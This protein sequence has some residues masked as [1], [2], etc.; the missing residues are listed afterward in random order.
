MNLLNQDFVDDDNPTHFKSTPS[1]WD[2]PAEIW[3]QILRHLLI[4]QPEKRDGD[5]LVVLSSE[6]DWTGQNPPNN[7]LSSQ[8]LG[9][10]RANYAIGVEILYGENVF[11][12]NGDDV[13]AFPN[14][15]SDIGR[16]NVARLRHYRL[17]HRNAGYE[18]CRSPPHY[19]PHSIVYVNGWCRDV[20][21]DRLFENFSS[22][23]NLETLSVAVDLPS[24]KMRDHLAFV[25]IGRYFRESGL[26]DQLLAAKQ[27]ADEEAFNY[28]FW[29][30]IFYINRLGISRAA[31]LLEDA[32][33]PELCN[34]MYYGYGPDGAYGVFST[35]ELD[36]ITPAEKQKTAVQLLVVSFQGART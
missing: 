7:L 3:L 35:K 17:D 6:S 16:S 8:V 4:K 36:S 15:L 18:D 23:R 32:W 21:L 9:T 11:E 5:S 20:W 25:E 29:Q 30:V 26:V 19:Y 1:F 31:T 13:W 28:L 14:F 34:H 33:F 27:M 10:N 22:L 12:M 24:W 2:L